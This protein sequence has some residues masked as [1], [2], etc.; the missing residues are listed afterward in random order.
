MLSLESFTFSM[1]SGISCILPLRVNLFPGIILPQ[2]REMCE[3]G[4]GCLFEGLECAHHIL[5]D[6][7]SIIVKD[8][9]LKRTFSVKLD[10]EN[11]GLSAS[12]AHDQYHNCL[13]EKRQ[14]LLPRQYM[15]SKLAP[16]YFS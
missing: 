6:S 14:L 15:T 4:W 16:V 13:L 9:V 10:K 3:A 7:P 5:P 8:K 1:I 2:E 12:K 11:F